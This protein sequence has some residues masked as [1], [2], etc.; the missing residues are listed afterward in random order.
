MILDEPTAFL[1]LPNRIEVMQVLHRLAS[2][3]ERT[4]LLSTHDLELALRMADVLWLMPNSGQIHTGIP[5]QLILDEAFTQVF[6]QLAFDVNS[7][8][9]AIERETKGT[10]VVIGD[11]VQAFWTRRA[12][13]RLGYDVSDMSNRNATRI[14]QIVS[15][16]WHVQT[17]NEQIIC[18]SL[19]DVLNTFSS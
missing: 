7:G 2:E 11:N 9:F 10:V 19:E 4:V 1:D 6:P 3:E 14:I 5:E 18:D 15:D 17:G 12:L 16:G 8:T 13:T